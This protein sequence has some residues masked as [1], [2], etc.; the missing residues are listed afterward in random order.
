MLKM[1]RIES[2]SY[3]R[4]D[5]KGHFLFEYDG[6]QALEVDSHTYDLIKFT[7]W[8]YDHYNRENIEQVVLLFDDINGKI[9]NVRVILHKLNGRREKFEIQRT[10]TYLPLV[11]KIVELF[12]DHYESL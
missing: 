5:N 1:T 8:L 6:G 2:S 10:Y 4:E 12:A 9:T 11:K 7:E 3:G